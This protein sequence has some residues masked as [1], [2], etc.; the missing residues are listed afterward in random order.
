M[1]NNKAWNKHISSTSPTADTTYLSQAARIAI[2]EEN[3]PLPLIIENYVSPDECRIL[4]DFFE[5][6]DYFRR[7]YQ[8]VVDATVRDC[9]SLKL[10][11]KY[12]S[13][14]RK[15]IDGEM[16]DYYN[17]RFCHKFS[18]EP[19]I[20][21]YG[22][23]VGMLPHHD[24]VTDIEIERA[25]TNKQPVMGGDYTV[26][27]LLNNLDDE[28]GGDLCFLN[29]MELNLPPRSGTI[30]GFRVDLVHQVK[31]ILCGYRYSLVSRVFIDEGS[32]I[33]QL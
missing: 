22:K 8:G 31:P 17:L 14:L 25:L 30:V 5:K 6:N 28:C 3:K 4:V 32:Q 13:L 29:F 26:V 12:Y 11:A 1:T 21:R 7:S 19:L 10:D 15:F 27:L 33:K 20:N 2:Q 23:G 18:T 9:F 24:M 16:S